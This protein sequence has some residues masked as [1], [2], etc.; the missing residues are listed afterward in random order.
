MSDDKLIDIIKQAIREIF[1]EELRE[2]MMDVVYEEA[3]NISKAASIAKM[4]RQTIYRLIKKGT[5]KT[6]PDNK[7]IPI[8]EIIKLT[9]PKRS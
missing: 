1:K 7:S 5:I 2:V 9:K 6:T 8:T 4:S 3:V